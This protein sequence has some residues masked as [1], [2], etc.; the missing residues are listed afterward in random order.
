MVESILYTVN[1]LK[2]AICIL[3]HHVRVLVSYRMVVPLVA[4]L[5]KALADNLTVSVVC[6]HIHEKQRP[7]IVNK[8]S[9]HQVMQPFTPYLSVRNVHHI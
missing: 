2:S 8:S 3:S 1:S 4:P 5:Q 7:S 6:S 9:L